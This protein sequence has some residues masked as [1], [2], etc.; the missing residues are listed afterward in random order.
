MVINFIVYIK[1]I[2]LDFSDRV[3]DIKIEIPK[4]TK[5]KQQNKNLVGGERAMHM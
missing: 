4:K 1:R 3:N 5:K 2:E